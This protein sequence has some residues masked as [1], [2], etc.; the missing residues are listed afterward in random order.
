MVLVI[1]LFHLWTQPSVRILG[2]GREF[3][4]FVPDL[5]TDLIHNPATIKV[6][7]K[8]SIS[9]N[10]IQIYSSI[11]SFNSA[12]L[13]TQKVD[14][15]FFE[16][17]ELLSLFVLYPKIGLAYRVG[18]WQRFD[19][20]NFYELEPWLYGQ[21][22]FL[23]GLN[24]GKWVK[25][26]AEYSFSWNNAP[27]RYYIISPCPAAITHSEWSNEGGLGIILSDEYKWQ[28]AFA[29]KKNWETNT[30]TADT[31][32]FYWP[33]DQPS[34]WTNNYSDLQINSRFKIK[35]KQTI[36]TA[37]L[38]YYEK[39]NYSANSRRCSYRPRLGII[40]QP[41]NNLFVI[42]AITYA[43]NKTDNSITSMEIIIPVGFER[44]FGSLI[45]FRMGNTFIYEVYHYTYNFF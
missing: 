20:R 42:G 30:F 39:D 28:F 15:E 22:G 2:F 19:Y 41:G 24:I 37:G 26:G 23:Y 40:Y 33:N 38:K 14:L 7:G 25:L 36:I 21:E 32:G 44:K 10:G 31:A 17:E 35:I 27:D 11:K 12:N 4:G 18:A 13:D 16:N 34:S 5:I 45:N 43:L 6:F 29:G 9:Y 3:A 1:I 8:D